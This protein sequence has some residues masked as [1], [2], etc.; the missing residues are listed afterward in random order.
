MPVMWLAIVALQVFCG[1][2]AVRNGYA[3]PWLFLIVFVPLIGCAIYVI[4]VLLPDIQSSPSARRTARDV[5]RVIDPDRD[6]RARLRDTEILGS[7]EN[8]RQLAE[9][10]L[11]RG[12]A[13]EAA[14]LFESAAQGPYADDPALLFGLGRAR[15]AADDPRGAQ[16]ALDHLRDTNPEWQSG[17]AHMIYARALEGQGKLDE[18]LYELEALVNY[19]AGEE[20]RVRLAL[21]YRRLGR[22]EEAR[23]LFQNA[24]ENVR[25]GTTFYKRQQREWLQ[26]AQAN[27]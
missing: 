19:F 27:L 7:A 1:V 22:T 21:L 17:A 5:V 8:K 16:Q 18:A 25:R 6:Y 10:C 4:A 9:E 11:A 20:A 12:N 23:A 15:L 2:H 14:A 26:V 24:V 3:M 13:A